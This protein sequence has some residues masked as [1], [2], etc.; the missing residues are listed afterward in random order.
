MHG[1]FD[2]EA[3]LTYDKVPRSYGTMCLDFCEVHFIT[4]LS[5]EELAGHIRENCY[6]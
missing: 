3:D 5:G 1:Y 4:E 2:F 6:S